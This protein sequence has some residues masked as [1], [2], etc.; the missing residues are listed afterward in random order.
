MKRIPQTKWLRSALML[1]LLAAVSGLLG[2]LFSLSYFQHA[3]EATTFREVYDY[4]AQGDKSTFL[5]KWTA[6]LNVENLAFVLGY[7]LR[8][9]SEQGL[10][11]AFAV[12]N[13]LCWM[14]ALYLALCPPEGGRRNWYLA[15]LFLFLY[16][17]DLS[18][19]AL[20]SYWCRYHRM[21]V[22]A[23]LLVLLLLQRALERGADRRDKRLCAAFSA[24]VLL[25]FFITTADRALLLVFAV[26]PLFLYF[27]LRWWQDRST[28]WR[29]F[30]AAAAAG[31]ALLA[32]HLVNLLWQ[33]RTGEELL[34]F[35]G[36][37][38]YLN[39]ASE[40][41]MLKGAAAYFKITADC[42]NAGIPEGQF[43][44]LGSLLRLLR[45]IAA[46]T[47][48]VLPFVL[49]LRM[50]FR[51]VRSV[52]PVDGIAALAV[53][54]DGAVNVLGY[55]E[56]ETYRYYSAAYFLLGLLL[57]RALGRWVEQKR[58]APEKNVT[59]RRRRA[60]HALIA[61]AFLCLAGATA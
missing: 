13:A 19:A 30:A 2:W 26:L 3:D 51:G 46:L 4:F 10:A 8:G 35:S 36:Y 22:L 7:G 31:A 55:N 6:W 34:S 16:I 15:A 5:G 25:F 52:H 50:L 20:G 43:A 29:V 54:C 27:L 45:L 60:E 40:R 42:W 57:C 1:L 18:A 23:L 61:A 59:P 37:G 32:L 48:A 44:S 14:P 58:L 17:P 53:L 38:S 11:A 12:C 39:W 28:R 47:A 21:P 49:V 41:Q 33:R 56:A 9:F 24:A